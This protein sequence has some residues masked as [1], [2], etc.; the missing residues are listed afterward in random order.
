MNENVEKILKAAAELKDAL[1]TVQWEKV[2][3]ICAD[4][5]TE[6]ILPYL[7]DLPRFCDDVLAIDF[8][9]V[10]RVGIQKFAKV[11]EELRS[12]AIPLFNDA[13]NAGKLNF[14]YNRESTN[15]NGS[16]VRERYPEAV[17]YYLE[18]VN[19]LRYL[20]DTPAEAEIVAA[21][22]RIRGLKNDFENWL[23]ELRQSVAQKEAAIKYSGIFQ[24]EAV[25]HKT[26][27]NLWL[28]ATITL[29]IATMALA[30][31]LLLRFEKVTGGTDIVQFTITK[32]IITVAL[33]YG[34]NMCLKSY[35][36][37]KHNQILNEH[38]H[39]ALQTFDLFE[40]SSNDS[41]TKSAVLLEVT[42]TIF[43]NQQTGYGGPNDNDGNDNL[44][45]KIVEIIK[46]K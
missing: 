22:T 39:N 18:L 44:P 4:S 17:G 12:R 29:L 6:D 23:D 37:Q 11:F 21:R 38:R 24:S 30:F 31:L 3:Q 20:T 8:E 1:L 28:V 14:Q 10:P 9:A 25:K 46:S 19:F 34:I 13:E 45:S 16:G 5:Q 43:A 7:R 26:A 15:Y 27:A 36:A 41:Q 35:R 2:Y 32:V 42:R 33:F 40:K